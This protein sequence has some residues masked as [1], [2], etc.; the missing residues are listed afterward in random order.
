MHWISA[1]CGGLLSCTAGD[2]R[3]TGLS[4]SPRPIIWLEQYSVVEMQLYLH[5]C[6]PVFAHF[7]CCSVG[8]D[9]LL[10]LASFELLWAYG[11][12]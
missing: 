6:Y 4:A 7:G 2:K 3:H 10:L 9:M 8:V 12:V 5:S 11:S 1:A